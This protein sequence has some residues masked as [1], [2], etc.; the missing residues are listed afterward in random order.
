[1]LKLLHWGRL[2]GGN[3]NRNGIEEH[4]LS[5]GFATHQNVRIS[6]R[7]GHIG[8]GRVP[9]NIENVRAQAPVRR[10]AN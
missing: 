7:I 5:A 8:I 9:L 6:R 4:C 1:L 10:F 3:T 2:S